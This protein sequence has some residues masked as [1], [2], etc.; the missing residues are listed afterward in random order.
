M[1]SNIE[2]PFAELTGAKQTM[3]SWARVIE[4][5]E[6]VPEVYKNSCKSVLQGRQPFPYVVLAPAISD[7]KQKTSEKLISEVEGVFYVWERAGKQ[8]VPTAFPLKDIYALE[9]GSVLLVSWLTISG[10]TSE[11]VGSSYSISFNTVT[12]RFLSPFIKKMRPS[13]AVVSEADWQAELAKF[14]YL[15]STNFKF[16]NYARES[17]VRGDKVICSILQPK[18]RKHIFTLFGQK[19][20]RTLVL[21][22]LALLTDKEAIFIRDDESTGEIKGRGE[23]Y[24]GVWRYIPLRS[25]TA[26]VITELENGL[27]TL[28]IELA[29]SDQSLDITFE[30]SNKKELVDFQRELSQAVRK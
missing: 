24:G 18:I 2:N 27:L 12:Q 16:M 11:G 6:D 22:H 29:A 13:P 23:R 30:A 15:S 8:I 3:S 25:I 4:S 10:L 1:T 14:D 26:A 21:S 28:S 19:F 5:Y 20:Y 7:F 9:V 17:L